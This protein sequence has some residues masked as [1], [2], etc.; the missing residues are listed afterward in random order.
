MV[1]VNTDTVLTADCEGRNS[2]RDKI[3]TQDKEEEDT[4]VSCSKSALESSS[5]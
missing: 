3:H 2:E 1:S 4:N 5:A